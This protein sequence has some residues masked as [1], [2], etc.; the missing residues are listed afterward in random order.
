MEL[1]LTI[2]IVSSGLILRSRLKHVKHLKGDMS[3]HMLARSLSHADWSRNRSDTENH[4]YSHY[5]IYS[6]GIIWYSELTNRLSNPHDI[7][8]IKVF[9]DLWPGWQAVARSLGWLKFEPRHA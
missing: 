1:T 3:T 2:P 4:S 7:W 6:L 5:R 8:Y 9:H